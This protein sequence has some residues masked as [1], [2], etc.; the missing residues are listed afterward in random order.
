MKYFLEK[1]TKPKSITILIFSIIIISSIFYLNLKDVN[2]RHEVEAYNVSV[3]I[4]NRASIVNAFTPESYYLSVA[5]L[6]QLEKF[7]DNSDEIVKNYVLTLDINH[8]D[9]LK[10]LIEFTHENE[11]KYLVIDEKD[12]K[13][14]FLKNIFDN[15]EKYPFLVKDYDSKDYGYLYH[16]KIFKIDYE[17]FS[18]LMDG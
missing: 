6:T 3:E 4:A 8:I 12:R 14:V 10:E 5:I 9:S 2:E 16:L 18:V 1:T 7:P 11:I 17:R 15:E 13:P